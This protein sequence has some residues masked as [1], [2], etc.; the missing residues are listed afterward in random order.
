MVLLRSSVAG[1]SALEQHLADRLAE[2]LVITAGQAPSPGERRAWTRSL[3]AL[4][5][6]LLD[7]GL[8]NVEMLIEYQLP[9][10]SKRVDAVLAGVDPRTGGPSYVVVELKQ[11]SEAHRFKDSEHLVAVEQYRRRGVSHP[12]IQVRDYC[13]Y[14]TNFVAALGDPTTRLSGAAYLHNATEAT[15]Q[16]LRDLPG[17]AHGRLFT[18]ER[19]GDFVSFLTER[20]APGRSGVP[21]ADALLASRIGPST[22]LLD[23]AAREVR[24]R[25]MFVLLDEQRDAYEHVLHAVAKARRGAT[26]TAVIVSGG[27]GSGKSVIALSLLG[28]LSRQGRAVLHA[29]GSRS[30]TQTLR[31]VAGNRAPQ[32]AKMFTYFNSYAAVEANTLECLILDEAHRIRQ[33]SASR[34][35]KASLRTGRPQVLELLEAARVPV[36]LLDQN[37]VVRP[38]ELGTA[39]D[40]SAHA[41]EL[42]MEVIQIDLDGQFRCG[43]SRVYVEWVERLLGLA[44]GGPV[45]WTPDG[46]FDLSVLAS[47][48]AMEGDLVRLLGEGDGARMAAG[49]CWPW[50]DPRPDGSLV[51]DVSIGGWSRPW[52]LKSDRSVGGAPPSSLW[53]TDPAGFG[54]VGC[55]Y[56]AQGFEYEHGGVIL[57]PDLVWREGRWVAVRE[58]NRD[59]DFRNRATVSDVDFDRLIRNVYKVLMTRG[60]RSM[61]LFSTD[62]ET[63]TFLRSLVQP[64][65]SREGDLGKARA[66][67]SSLEVGQA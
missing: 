52:N 7:A 1:F 58:A 4:Q 67:D 47:P 12:L 36:F 26:K 17:D 33:T 30:F 48:E 42:G 15:V 32:V 45:P 63:N 2:Q 9:L 19:K 41:R 56:T 34:W 60:L 23:V 22:Q 24:E 40:I 21:A 43:G 65:R 38:G 8:D 55:V 29:T 64:V 13:D 28:E 44:P 46:R 16:D 61:R 27:P 3:P 20:L 18:A 66:V 50:S 59:P 54:Q 11:W 62:P 37:Q 14:L 31:K 25:T 35:T 10:S 57:G 53:A 5:S 6:V 51:P 49:Y 39:E